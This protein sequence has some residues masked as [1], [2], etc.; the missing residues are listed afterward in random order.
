M[1]PSR[2]GT[3][4]WALYPDKVVSADISSLIREPSDHVRTQWLEL[5]PQDFGN[6]NVSIGLLLELHWSRETNSRAAVGCT[7]QSL[8]H[9]GRFPVPKQGTGTLNCLAALELQL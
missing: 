7:L 2:D 8:W 6:A 9:Q 5:P 1:A 3:L 4:P